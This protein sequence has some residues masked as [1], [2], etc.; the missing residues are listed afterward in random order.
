[1]TQVRIA[2]NVKNSQKQI[3]CVTVALQYRYITHFI[4]LNRMASFTILELVLSIVLLS[5]SSDRWKTDFTSHKL[6]AV[7]QT[8]SAYANI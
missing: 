8:E 2:A 6:P 1:M 3:L 7:A 4:N 5:P